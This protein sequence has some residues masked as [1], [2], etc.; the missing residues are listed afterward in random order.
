M[1]KE[2]KIRIADYLK[3][4]K[5]LKSLGATFIEAQTFTDIYFK[6]TPG[7]ILKLAKVNNNYYQSVLRA[8]NGKFEFIKKQPLKESEVEKIK[9]ELT[10]KYGIKRILKGRRRNFLLGEFMITLNLIEDIGNFLI[11]IGENPNEKFIIEKLG[12]KNPEY[13]RVSFDELQK[14]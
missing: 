3:T 10:K 11:L 9:N 2:L 7:K 5:K 12:I 4:E 14:Q 6:Q 8:V 13:I 1:T